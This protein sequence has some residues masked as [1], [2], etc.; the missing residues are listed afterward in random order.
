LTSC[1]IGLSSLQ[2]TLE[3]VVAELK[4]WR[5]Y[6][7]INTTHLCSYASVWH[8]DCFMQP[9]TGSEWKR[10][11]LE[12]LLFFRNLGEDVLVGRVREIEGEK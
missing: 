7:P 3:S 5:I 10:L 4:G 6:S 9:E 1:L 2:K 12:I 8:E 11:S